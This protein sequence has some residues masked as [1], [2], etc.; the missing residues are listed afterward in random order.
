VLAVRISEW[1]LRSPRLIRRAISAVLTAVLRLAGQ[2]KAV[3]ALKALREIDRLEAASKLD[4]ARAVR[5]RALA[6]VDPSVTAPLWCSEGFDRLR[7]EDMAGALEAFE[8][9]IARL[10]GSAAV[11]GVAEP[12]RLYYGATVAAIKTG[13]IETARHYYARLASLLAS[14][15]EVAR[16]HKL[17]DPT[18]QWDASLEWIR[19]R[20]GP[21]PT[22]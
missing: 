8:T 2:G 9:G 22:S 16:Q 12:D 1:L 14:M 11:Y 4:E 7:R 13:K 19:A 18:R 21:G 3:V 6:T 15:S 10:D 17:E 5:Q 20:I